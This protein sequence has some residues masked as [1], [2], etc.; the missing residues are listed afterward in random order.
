MKRFIAVLLSLMLVLVAVG[1]GSSNTAEE[2][3]SNEAVTETETEAVT[4]P[5]ELEE[6][7]EDVE[8]S[9]QIVWA[10]D[11]G[12]GK[13]I[14]EILDAFEAKNPNIKVNLL[15]GTQDAQKV[16]SLILSG[17]A[18]EVIQ[19]PYRHVQAIGEQGGF[20]ELTGDFGGNKDLF[21]DQIWQLGEFDGSLFGYPWMGH[22]IQLV[23]NK[24]MFDEAGLDKAPETWDELYEYAK[25][26]TIDKDGD[27]TIDQYG[28]GLIGKQSHDITWMFNMFVTQAGAELIKEVDGKER[29]A[30]NSDEGKAAL[31]FYSKL[32]Q[33]V[34]PPDTA[35]KNG[36]DVMADFRNGITAMEFQG[37]W[38]VTDIWKN[39]NPFEVSAAEVPAGSAG[40]AADIGPYM[41]T[42][43]VGVEDQKLAASK[44]LIEFLG[45][46]EGQ[47]MLMKGEVADDGNYYPF[48]VPIRK[49]MKDT[50]Y[51]KEHPELLV[52][53]KGFEY[54]SISTPSTGWIRVEEEVYQSQLNQVMT[55]QL[56]PEEA[57]MNI[58]EMGNKILD[59]N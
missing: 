45:S 33:E 34:C 55:G 1:C 26:L 54:P 50:D 19:V 53:I 10:E 16:L 58:E 30:I 15:G 9:M 8:I 48:R 31:E 47:E 36:G 4:E 2:N 11:S 3:V 6:V 23:Y 42:V 18:P 57:L 35:N 51:F 38:G 27:G 43:P 59:E 5:V 24:T 20:V 44:L 39:G 41:L 22:S 46:K 40:R 49:D 21:F 13:A 56:T 14:R 52:F 7:E 25:T 28:L 29:I 37:P 17:E 12:R 32:V